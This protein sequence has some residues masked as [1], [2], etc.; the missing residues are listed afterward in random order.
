MLSTVLTV[1]WS[2]AGVA[3]STGAAVDSSSASLASLASLNFTQIMPVVGG[4]DDP[5]PFLDMP[6]QFSSAIILAQTSD[7]WN[8]TFTGT[9][10]G[11]TP[12][13]QQRL[14]GT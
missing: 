5:V 9:I 8:Q 12:T 1:A 11:S 2:T 7:T 13:K 14:S 10:W 4:S 3:G 6:A